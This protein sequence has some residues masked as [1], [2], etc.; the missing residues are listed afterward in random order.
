[1]INLSIIIP[2]FNESKSLHKLLDACYNASNGR[3]DI[4]FI[5]VNNGSNDDTEVILEELLSQEKYSFG[6][7]LLIKVNIG[8]GNGI[9]QG[10]AVAKGNVLSWTHAD[11]QTDPNDVI[12]AYELNKDDLNLNQCIVKGE[13]KG[14]NIFDNIFTAG[15]SILSSIFLKQFLWDVNAQ[16]KIF[17]RKF[18]EKFKKAPQD[19]SLDLYLLFIAN[20]YK[21][22]IKR[23]QVFFSKRLYGKAKGGGTFRG[24]Y[25][26]IKRTI[27]C[28]IELQKEISKGNS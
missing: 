11:L 20:K 7:S 22:P 18:L 17:H 8:Y 3:S 23:Y 1:M 4:E 26:L 10:L 15:M 12:K 13:R 28:I 6:K 19:F 2:C 25:N 5:F 16:P 9:L 24:K 21:I 14:R 27:A